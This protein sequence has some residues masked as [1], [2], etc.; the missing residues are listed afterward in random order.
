M[1]PV[2]EHTKRPGEQFLGSPGDML[3]EEVIRLLRDA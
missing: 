1:T 2:L 3:P